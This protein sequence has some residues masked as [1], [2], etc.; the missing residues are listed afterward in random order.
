[1]KP[2][3]KVMHKHI[4]SVSGGRDI[5]VVHSLQSPPLIYE[6]SLCEC[7]SCSVSKLDSE[8]GHDKC[9]L[10]NSGRSVDVKVHRGVTN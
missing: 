1:M 8:T 9:N 7:G 3:L 5:W 10:H 4:Y 6:G 2:G